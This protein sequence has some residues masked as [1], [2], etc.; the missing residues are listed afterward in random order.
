LAAALRG[1]GWPY[2]LPLG[3]A[4]LLAALPWN[5]RGKT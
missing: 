1:P 3:A 4:C 5:H 2:F